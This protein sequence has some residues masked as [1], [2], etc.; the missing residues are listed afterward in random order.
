MYTLKEAIAKARQ[1]IKMTHEFFAED[2]YI[3]VQN[4]MIIFEDGIRTP[5]QDWFEDKPY[6][7]EGW[8]EFKQ[9]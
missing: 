1:G 2:E 4:G 5:L 6:L 3:L 7:D 9:Y 8:S